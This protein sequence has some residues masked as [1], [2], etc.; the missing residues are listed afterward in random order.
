MK[1]ILRDDVK[2]VGAAGE[3]LEVKTGYARNF[4]L[5]Q[6][7]A[8][9]ATPANMKVYENEKRLMAKRV[10]ENR[11]EAEQ[12]KAEIEKLSLTVSVKVGEDERLFGSVTTHTIADLLTEKGHEINHR[13]IL[14]D[15]PIRELGVFEVGV[16]LSHGVEAKVKL[17]VVKE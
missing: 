15:E 16:D 11:R 3:V 12:K 14:L 1:V 7:L 13:K 8:Y 5:P 6:N 9:P 10:A 17:W 2:G 4:L